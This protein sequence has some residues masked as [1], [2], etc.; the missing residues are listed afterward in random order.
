MYGP[1]VVLS[2]PMGGFG[3][4]LEEFVEGVREVVTSWRFEGLD[5]VGVSFPGSF[6]VGDG[7]GLLLA[8]TGLDFGE[9]EEL[10]DLPLSLSFSLTLPEDFSDSEED[11]RAW[12]TALAALD[13]AARG[14]DLTRK[15]TAEAEEVLCWEFV[16]VLVLGLE[17][18]SWFRPFWKKVGEAMVGG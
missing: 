11:C 18:L 5:L 17:L 3:V 10:E 7:L 12:E 8:G 2:R 16:G 13:A 15:P 4:G 6:G 1:R 9:M 14:V